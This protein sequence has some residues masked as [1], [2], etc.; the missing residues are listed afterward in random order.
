MGFGSEIEGSWWA[1]GRSCVT[2]ILNGLG[3]WSLHGY[4]HCLPPRRYTPQ[5]LSVFFPWKGGS[6]GSFGLASELFIL[7]SGD[8]Y[9]L[10]SN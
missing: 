8:K 6:Q 5:K 9:P 7:D 2:E 1:G 10:N 4:V 3:S